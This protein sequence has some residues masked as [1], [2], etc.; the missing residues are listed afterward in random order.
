MYLHDCLPC[1]LGSS[2]K[3]NKQTNFFIHL[4]WIDEIDI[5]L[6]GKYWWSFLVEF[7]EIL[8]FFLPYI[9]Q[10]SLPYIL[11]CNKISW[12]CVLLS[13][14][15]LYWE[16]EIL[17]A[18]FFAFKIIIHGNLLLFRTSFPT[19]DFVNIVVML[20]LHQVFLES[21]H[22]FFENLYCLF[23][24]IIARFSCAFLVSYFAPF[25]TMMNFLIAETKLCFSNWVFCGTGNPDDRN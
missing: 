11:C 4:L 13:T 24:Q 6:Q 1:L 2:S 7:W 15:D 20:F 3:P 17:V 23:E 25:A 10:V 21:W 9:Y 16:Q 8:D 5:F 18:I 19:Q 22:S 14:I 12:T